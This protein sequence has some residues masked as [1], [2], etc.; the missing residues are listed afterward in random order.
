MSIWFSLQNP[1]LGGFGSTRRNATLR[2]IGDISRY[3]CRSTLLN[4]KTIGIET[5]VPDSEPQE[6]YYAI[7]SRRNHRHGS[8]K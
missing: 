4:A 1:P 7:G 8:R 2:T 3:W 5:R 6:T